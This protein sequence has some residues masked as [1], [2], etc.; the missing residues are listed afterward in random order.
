MKDGEAE[1]DELFEFNEGESG[2]QDGFEE[3]TR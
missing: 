2:W 3:N 1:A